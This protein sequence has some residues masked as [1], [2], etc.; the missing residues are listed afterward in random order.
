MVKTAPKYI[1]WHHTKRAGHWLGWKILHLFFPTVVHYFTDKYQNRHHHLVVDT[2]YSTTAIVLL[3]TNVALGIWWLKIFAPVDVH[4]EVQ[5]PQHMVSNSP[6][7]VDVLLVNGP[8]PVSEVAVEVEV[9]PG[10]ELTKSE[11]AKEQKQHADGSVD[12]HIG[13]LQPFEKQHL[14]IP[15]WFVGQVGEVSKVRAFVR[16]RHFNH[17]WEVVDSQS[18]AVSSSN[19]V[20]ESTIPKHVLNEQIFDWPIQFENNST[21]PLTNAQIVLTLPSDLVIHAVEGGDYVADQTTLQLPDTL[22]QSNGMVHVQAAFHETSDSNKIISLDP[23]LSNSQGQF[24]SQGKIDLGADA[25]RP[26][27]SIQVTPSRSTANLGDT[28]YY[29]IAIQNIGDAS[30]DHCVVTANLSGEA[31]N[32]GRI[33]A[34]DATQSGN[35]LSWTIDQTLEPQASTQIRFSVSTLP[36][37]TDHNL[38][39]GVSVN[40]QANISDIEV[41]TISQEV[42][43]EVKFNSHMTLDA[44]ALFTGPSGEEFG[45]G[46]WPTQVNQITAVRVFWSVKNVNNSIHQAVISTTLPGQVEWTNNF[47]VSYG[48]G[49]TYHAASRTV[50]WDVGS[51]P[52]D[53]TTLGVSFEVR[54][55]PNYLQLGKVIRLTNETSLSAVD[56]FTG[57]HLFQ[58]AAPVFTADPV[59]E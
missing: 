15:G 33:Y 35:T 24:V 25:L 59:Q 17:A 50:T 40:A 45:Y 29:T 27:I 10:F 38:S 41:K 8:E 26:R 16:Y 51:L 42:S 31:F 12:V 2:V 18:F 1:L 9:P 37:L 4:V 30:L 56:S 39:A 54:V 48:T 34:P 28:I 44:T 14:I 20:V 5:V 11:Q 36:S 6:T 52:A 7:D 43:S 23:Q 32:L 46:P 47:S 3:V 13:S 58:I 19:F 57:S 53:G 55:L 49:L 22:A 21:R